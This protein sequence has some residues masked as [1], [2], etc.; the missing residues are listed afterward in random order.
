MTTFTRPQVVLEVLESGRSG[1][2]MSHTTVLVTK[3]STMKHGSA[4]VAAGTE[5]A[6][7]NVA[8]VTGI[9]DDLAINNVATG[10]TLQVSVA[11]KFCLFKTSEISYSNAGAFVPANATILKVLNQFQ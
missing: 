9:I 6:L 11:Q 7:L 4:L 2:T 3:T 8:L 5:A 10:G 1:Q